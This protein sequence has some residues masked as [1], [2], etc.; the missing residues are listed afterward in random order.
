MD[1]IQH[2][3]VEKVAK[4][5]ERGLDPNYHD[6]DTGG[7]AARQTYSTHSDSNPLPANTVLHPG[8]APASCSGLLDLNAGVGLR[9]VVSRAVKSERSDALCV[10]FYN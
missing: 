1:L 10:L 7:E 9:G 6:G 8:P 2:N 3:Q 4:M 5:L